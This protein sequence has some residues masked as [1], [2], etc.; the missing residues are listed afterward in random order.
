MEINK[1]I[2]RIT[3]ENSQNLEKFFKNYFFINSGDSNYFIQS[4]ERGT[5]LVLA[6]LI[7]SQKAGWIEV[8]LSFSSPSKIGRKKEFNLDAA[9]S[10]EKEIS[11][12]I[13]E[14]TEW[15]LQTIQ[16]ELGRK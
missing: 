15:S 16:R 3:E 14:T 10:D 5:N 1:L 12:V 11:R 6:S 4:K 9:N 2:A 8:H 7:P 13:K